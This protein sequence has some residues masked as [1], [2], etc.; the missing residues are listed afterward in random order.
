VKLSGAPGLNRAVTTDA[1]GRWRYDGVA[2]D[3][4]R[5]SL[6]L[7]HPD[8]A[9]DSFYVRRLEDDSLAEARSLT[10]VEVMKKEE[11]LPIDGKVLMN[12][13]GR[14]SRRD[15]VAEAPNDFQGI[16]AHGHRFRGGSICQRLP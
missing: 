15:A 5:I 9:S 1:Q 8:Y 10:H 3:V 13:V 6:L 14:R 16:C 11:G 4:T 7:R 2:R 12:K